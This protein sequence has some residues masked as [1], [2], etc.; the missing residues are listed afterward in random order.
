[1]TPD[2]PAMIRE[3]TCR[4]ARRVAVTAALTLLVALATVDPRRAR[5]DVVLDWNE[6]ALRITAAAA[7]DPPLE[8]RNLAILHLA[9][10]DAVNAISGECE[11]YLTR[12][13]AVAGAA[14]QAAAAAAAHRV[15]VRLYPGQQAQADLVYARSLAALPEGDR[16]S[17]GVALGEKVAQEILALRAADGAEQARLPSVAAE[18]GATAWVPTPPGFLSPLDP[19][20]G[21]VRPF[22]LE[23]GSQ[24]RPAPPPGPD[25]AEQARDFAEIKEIGAA[26]SAARTDAQTDLARLWIATGAQNWNPLLRQVAVARR[27]TVSQNARVF[28]L[29]NLA[30]AD[31]FI[32]AWDAK[33]TWNQ[34][35]PVTAIRA[36]AARDGAAGDAEWT[37]ALTT[38]PFPDYIAGHT[39][40][41]G[42]AERVLERLFGRRP[43]ITLRL[44]SATAPGVVRSYDSFAGI[45]E[46]IV[47]ARVWGGIHWRTSCVRG[48]AVGQRIGD[49]V[50]DHALRPRDPR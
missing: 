35:R 3:T 16:R 8:A 37:P 14:P 33:F 12:S 9:I 29:V 25:S 15:L 20:W 45:S 26:G 18:A 38:P 32:A 46:G 5:A 23:R 42:A 4:R 41:G 22:A 19:G 49:Y 17:A 47:D 10:F 39:T 2:G 48:R 50:A 27:L 44:R 6:V 36:A 40:Y 24:F 21:A 11:P 1:M 7:F 34:W 31:A 28:A 30:G 43:G 13:R